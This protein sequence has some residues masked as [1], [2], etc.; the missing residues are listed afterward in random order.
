MD[1]GAAD[2]KLATASSTCRKGSVIE[3]RGIAGKGRTRKD[4]VS[5]IY[6]ISKKGGTAEPLAPA[7]LGWG[8]FICPL[9]RLYRGDKCTIR[10]SNN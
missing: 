5:I 3:S 8:F 1:L 4:E 10:E 2:R 9:L 7:P 6:E